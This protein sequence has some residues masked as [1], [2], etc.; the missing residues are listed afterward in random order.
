MGRDA[1][2]PG[3][4]CPPQNGMQT[5]YPLTPSPLLSSDWLYYLLI[6]S[7]LPHGHKQTLHSSSFPK[8]V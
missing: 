1:V 6:F 8:N 4:P 5:G 3:N 7:Q 2:L